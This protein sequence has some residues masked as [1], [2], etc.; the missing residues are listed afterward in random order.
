VKPSE[1][2]VN[3]RDELRILSAAMVFR[4]PGCSDRFSTATT[5]TTTT[6]AT[7]MKCPDRGEDYLG[8]MAEAIDRTTGYL[9]PWRT[10]RFSKNSQVQYAVIEIVGEDANKINRTVA[11]FM[12]QHPEFSSCEEG[13]PKG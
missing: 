5:P 13:F 6:S 8:H 1:A 11:D 7:R 4:V 12:Q 9:D 10:Q 2:L 3:Y